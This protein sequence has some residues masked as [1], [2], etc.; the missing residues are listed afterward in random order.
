MKS[1]DDIC[2]I[3]F[4]SL[5]NGKLFNF[6]DM[7]VSHITIADYASSLSKINRFTGWTKFP[8]CVTPDMKILTSDLLWIPCGN[9]KSGDSLL[10]FDE[11]PIGGN[12]RSRRKLKHSEVLQA[13]PIK[14]SV[15]EFEMSDGTILKSSNKHPWL[16]CKN[17]SKNQVWRT[18]EDIV[19]NLSRGIKQYMLKFLEPWTFIDDYTSG[20]LAGIF[21]GEGSINLA[22]GRSNICS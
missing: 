16:I 18:T 20:Y 12:I 3:G 6:R 13:Y 7:N 21:D 14:E 1:T 9:L 2:D 11:Y 17:V 8:Y 15:Y 5:G 10:A 22:Q 4:I 19:R